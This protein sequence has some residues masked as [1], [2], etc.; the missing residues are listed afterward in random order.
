MRNNSIRL[1]AR[2]DLQLRGTYD[3]P[4]LFGRAEVERGEVPFEG[5]A[6]VVTRGS[7]DFNNPTRIEPFFDIET[8]TRVRVPGRD[9]PRHAARV[10]HHRP[11]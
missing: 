10:R 9:L 3:R 7:I 11:R 8:E 4:L 1:T 6:T 2:A 5:A